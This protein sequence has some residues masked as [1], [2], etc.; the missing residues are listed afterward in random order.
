[1]K[2]FPRELR[3]GSGAMMYLDNK[4][5]LLSFKQPP[6]L[7]E[8]RGLLKANGLEFE[9]IR[10]DQK[11][12]DSSRSLLPVISHTATKFWVRSSSGSA[13]DDE[14]F[15]KINEVLS[16]FIDWIG[17][18]YQLVN[19]NGREGLLCPFPNVLI[20]EFTRFADANKDLERI[21]SSYGLVENTEKSKYLNGKKYL[22]IKN[23]HQSNAY[24]IFNS[25]L[26]KEK[27][28]IS[29]LYLENMPMLTD[30]TLIPN[31][32]L[33]ASQWG[34]TQINAPGGWDI[35]AG[36][37]ATIV[38]IIDYA[39]DLT[40]PDISYLN[41]GINLSTLAPTADPPSPADPDHGTACA[42]IISGG[43]NNSLGVAGLAG[44]CR[45][46]P[47]ARV[48]GTDAELA[49]GINYAADNGAS[50]LSMS[51][52]RYDT[53]EGFGPTGW[54]FTIIDPAIEHAVNDMD[55]VLCAA[56]GNENTGTHN[57]YPARH[58]LVMACG[59]S[60][61]DDNRK[62]PASPDPENFWG[63]NFGIDVYD[64]ETTG[65]SV[66]A[67]GVLIPTTDRQ[68]TAGYNPSAGTGGDY[69][70][71]FNGTSS[72]TPHVAAFAGLIRSQYST[73]TNIEVRRIIETTAERVGLLAYSE[74]S[75]KNNGTWNQEM[76]YGR[77]NVFR[78]LDQSDVMIKDWSGDDG[79]EPSNPP[80][81][82]FW[83]F[84]DIVVRIFDDNVFNPSNPSQSKNVEKGQPNFVYVQVTNKGP[85][86]ARN[87][88]VDCRITPWIGIQFR[89]PDDWTLLDAM[90]VQPSPITATFASVASGATAMAKFTIS[91]AQTDTLYG[92]ENSN[93]WHPCLLAS[94]VSDNDYAFAS[95]MFGSDPLSQLKNN[96]AQRNLSVID[97]LGDGADALSAF[98][99]IAGHIKNE[100]RFMDIV[101]E[102]I[103]T[104]PGT[105]IFLNLDDDG[106]AFPLVD[107]D[108]VN[109]GSPVKDDEKGLVFL[110]TTKVE[111][112]LGC[113]RGILTIR[114]GSRFDCLR[115]KHLKPI[116]VNGGE[117][118][119]RNDKRYVELRGTKMIVQVE[120]E[121]GIIYPMSIVFEL[122]KK[123]TK[124]SEFQIRV[125]QRD[126]RG[127]T[128][129][130]ASAIY[131]IK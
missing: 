112:V 10:E 83:D 13:I 1:M 108:R 63:A 39:F 102:N 18:V 45:I 8:L 53:G 130:G 94:V 104:V 11:S 35:T 64:G 62:S 43:F 65:I 29:K 19:T 86:D 52:G 119:I 118:I 22:V 38:A 31:D 50:I 89:Y 113:C 27:R 9:E 90:H 106:K 51:F 60:S 81:G 21:L 115:K 79:V 41:T 57:R 68:G 76:G 114:K 98:P 55:C 37:A 58:P 7:E 74:T 110:E 28:V 97:V 2:N 48:D 73:L 122:P 23:V 77:I 101:V 61:T 127:V 109:Q 131:Y 6:S 14:W 15:D 84:S 91:S 111:T 129:G 85:R 12:K 56:S 5:L 96:L 116:K 92:W 26:E 71:T 125:S 80:G 42:G 49:I 70:M 69:T 87:V 59:A 36:I 123:V 103:K 100:E 24:S 67:P 126:Q 54:N 105:K 47:L 121:P 78:G 46:L 17:P 32:T 40:H 20:A 25:L 117:V 95:A 93:P 124:G 30:N 120:K 44:G 88:V 3:H 33:F 66:V 82:D 107:F 75:G 34:M 72:A 16:D 4:R 99:F 128:V